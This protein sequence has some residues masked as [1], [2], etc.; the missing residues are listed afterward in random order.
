MHPSDDELMER[1]ARGDRGA[2]AA[3]YA[4]HADRVHRIAWRYLGDDEAARDTLQDV[5]VR[6]IRAAPRYR[7]RGTFDAWLLT[8]TYNVC[9]NERARAWRRLRRAPPGAPP[10]EERAGDGSAWEDALPD[11][12][13]V[14]GDDATARRRESARVRRALQELPERARMAVVLRYYEGHDHAA[15]AAALGSTVGAVTALL[16][17][18]RQ[19]LAAALGDLAGGDAD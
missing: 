12:A 16:A 17:R 8:L 14:P 18:T 9:R 1:T 7:A 5:F 19:T 4:R 2:G 13:A 10:A 6:L 11:E 15:I 3:L